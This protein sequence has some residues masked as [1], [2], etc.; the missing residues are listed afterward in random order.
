MAEELLSTRDAQLLS[1]SWTDS[2]CHLAMD[3]F[4]ADRHDVLGRCGEAGVGR[5]VVVGTNPGDW[6]ACADLARSP[7]RRATAGVHPHEASCWSAATRAAL[8]GALGETAVSAVGEIGLDYHYDLSPRE[9][10]REAFADQLAVAS[11]RRLPVVVHSREAFED[12]VGMLSEHAPGL[13][14]VIHCFTYGPEEARAFLDLGLHLSFSGIITFPKAPLI[15][16]AALLTP[17]DRLLVETDAPY[18]APVPY[19]GKRCE[20]AHVATVGR[21]VA[22]LK[23]LEESEAARQTTLNAA[24]LFGWE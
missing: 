14:G 24:R 19:R 7:H 8:E 22:A 1:A 5:V 9:I 20:P 13:R 3:A 18:L 21:F 16:E 11:E 10:Q 15:R 6:R 23:G 2:H 17:W 4:D 12:T